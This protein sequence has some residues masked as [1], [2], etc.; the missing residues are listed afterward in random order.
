MRVTNAL[1]KK[2]PSEPSAQSG[3]D[4]LSGPERHLENIF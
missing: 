4:T 1:A 2:G 3:E